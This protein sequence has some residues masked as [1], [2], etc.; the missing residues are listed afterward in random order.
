MSAGSNMRLTNIPEQVIGWT[1]LPAIEVPGA[2]G[3]AKARTQQIG[4]AQLRLIEYSPGY[5]AD[6]WCVKG[7]VIFVVSGA[8][9][10]EHRDGW[11]ACTLS[12]GMSWCVAD[13]AGAHRVRS[14]H[15]ATI[16]V[17]D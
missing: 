11:A 2:S 12:A 13:D 14:D 3:V 7:H 5:R 15:G 17:L 1:Q 8:L 9:A 16:F 10:I 4:E 6:H